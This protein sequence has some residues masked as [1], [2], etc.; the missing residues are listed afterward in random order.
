MAKRLLNLETREHEWV[1]SEKEYE[2]LQEDSTFLRNL[3]DAGV[4]NWDGY[5]Y[6]YGFA[7]D[8]EDED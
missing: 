3:R 8:G 5:C 7:D 6:G 2:S 1:L 4:D